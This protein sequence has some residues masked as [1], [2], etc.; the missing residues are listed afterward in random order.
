MEENSGNDLC[1]REGLLAVTK[2]EERAEDEEEEEEDEEEEEEEEKEEEECPEHFFL[3]FS[4]DLTEDKSENLAARWR[5]SFL[6]RFVAGSRLAGLRL[7][8]V[9]KGAK[10]P[11]SV[12]APG[13]SIKSLGRF[14]LILPGAFSSAGVLSPKPSSFHIVIRVVAHDNVSWNK[15]C[16]LEP[17]LGLENST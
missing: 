11:S 16:G 13:L 8:L 2:S 6:K 12:R 5:G 9:G 14:P 15:C 3:E 17:C 7:T 1:W 10:S 4:E